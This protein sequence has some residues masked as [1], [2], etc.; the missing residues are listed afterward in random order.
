MTRRPLLLLAPAILSLALA[1]CISFG[2]KPP[3][4]LF[5]L[6]PS[7]APAAGPVSGE[8]RPVVIAIP[9]VPEK[10]ATLRVPVQATDVT[11]AYLKDA[12][13]VESPPG[14][15]RRLLAETMAARTGRFVLPAGDFAAA[16]ADS[17]SGTLSDFGLDAR[18][19]EVVVTFEALDQRSGSATP[20]GRRF[21]ARVPVVSA[22]PNLVAV[23]LNQAANQV[24]AEVAD[25]VGR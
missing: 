1:G 4:F 18:T 3:P 17:V 21:T 20:I 10:L 12:Q 7:A 6:T 9:T 25:W 11:L 16:P 2:A 13:W 14:L 8:G 5:T 22:D 19:M 23:S 24:A 15:F